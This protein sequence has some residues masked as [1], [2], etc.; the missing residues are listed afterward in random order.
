MIAWF[1]KNSIA[2]NLLAAAIIGMGLYPVFTNQIPVE[3]FPSTDPDVISVRVPYRGS[4]PV[5]VETA[6]VIRVEE[7]VRDRPYRSAEGI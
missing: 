7:A 6:V 2:A 4:T 5:E 3:F 1:T